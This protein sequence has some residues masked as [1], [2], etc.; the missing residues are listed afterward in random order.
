MIMNS[1]GENLTGLWFDGS[2]D[3]SKH[4]LDCEEKELEIF[5]ETKNWLDIYFSEKNPYFIP[6][7][8][9]KDLGKK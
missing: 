8:K 9:I 6:K 5:K 1:D 3:T 4:V 2:R 7:Y